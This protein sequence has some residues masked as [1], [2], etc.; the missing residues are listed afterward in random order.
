ME[1]FNDLVDSFLKVAKGEKGD[2]GKQGEK[3]EPGEQ[4]EKGNVGI[5][6]RGLKGDTFTYADMSEDDKADLVDISS[7]QWTQPFA[8]KY[9]KLEQE[10]AE[11]LTLAKTQLAETKTEFQAVIAGSTDGD[12]VI[13]ARGVGNLTLKDRLDGS[14]V[15]L[16][17]IEQNFELKNEAVNDRV[18]L[19]EGE[20]DALEL[21]KVDKVVGKQLSDENYT[22]IEKNKLA[23]V[24]ENAT[25]DMT[26]L[27]IKTEYESNTDTNAYTD[28]EKEKV[29]NLPDDTNARLADIENDK[30]EKTDVGLLSGLLTTAKTSI[31]NAINELFNSK[32]N[33]VQEAWKTPT[34]LNG[35]TG[36]LRYRKTEAGSVQFQGE[37]SNLPPALT[38]FMTLPATYFSTSFKYPIA[39]GSNGM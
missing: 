3:G 4:G 36:N 38:P 5:G 35:A 33:R 6:L 7:G 22:I 24:E 25:A 17:D 27:E 2:P 10:Y 18:G 31:V 28:V 26:A 32:A 14:D 39:R 8:E 9:A 29:A 15:Q 1:N 11:D 30:A 12:E 37:I 19:V 23:G 13:N 16:A 21:G 34:L 20:V